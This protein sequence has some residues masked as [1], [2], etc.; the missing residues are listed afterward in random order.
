MLEMA[1]S[2]EQT[3]SLGGR[4]FA[5][6][7]VGGQGATASPGV[8]LDLSA[9]GLQHTASVG[10]FFEGGPL[11][12]GGGEIIGVAIVDYRPNGIDPGDVAQAPDIA[13]ICTRILR[14]ADTADTIT[15]EVADEGD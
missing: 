3:D 2:S 8:L 15:I 1:S 9:S 10:T 7:G 14:C 12:N 11:L 13:A 5:L 6:S 4:L